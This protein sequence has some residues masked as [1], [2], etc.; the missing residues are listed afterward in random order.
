FVESLT[1][2][3]RNEA[4]QYFDRIDDLGGMLAAIDKNFFRREIADAAFAYQRE[5]DAKRKL[6]VGVNAF[7]EA[8]EKPLE[9]LVIDPT[10]EREQIARLNSIKANRDADAVRRNLDAVKRAAGTKT[11]L[12]PALI[13]A[14]R[15]RCTVGELMNAM[16]DVFGRYDASGRW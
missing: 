16:A 4:K 9:T 7:T 5:V 10:V 11:N 3:M 15:A 14:A 2:Q 8:E 1:Q 6:I 12:M 13:D